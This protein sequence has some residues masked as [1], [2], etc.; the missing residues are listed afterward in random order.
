[1]AMKQRGFPSSIGRAADANSVGSGF[2]SWGKLILLFC[3]MVL[4]SRTI[5]QNEFHI[6]GDCTK[7]MLRIGVP[8]TYIFRQQFDMQSNDC[9]SGTSVNL[10]LEGISADRNIV[11]LFFLNV[12][13]NKIPN[14]DIRYEEH[15]NLIGR[16]SPIEDK[17]L[18]NTVYGIG[19]ADLKKDETFSITVIAFNKDVEEL[20][21]TGPIHFDRIGIEYN[22]YYG[23]CF[24]EWNVGLRNWVREQVRGR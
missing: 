7:R 4:P 6:D 22:S 8:R 1:M 2:K 23:G 21:D 9:Y 16:F 14:K 24:H 18:N 12:D 11:V 19:I 3:L 15:P 10:K 17:T 5:A 13:K 20:K